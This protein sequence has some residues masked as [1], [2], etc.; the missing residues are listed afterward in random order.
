MLL[1][2]AANT[3]K[4][5][6]Y[7]P[8]LL[9]NI[10][11]HYQHSPGRALFRVNS[12]KPRDKSRFSGDWRRE[13][14]SGRRRRGRTRSPHPPVPWG[15]GSGESRPSAPS[16]QPGDGTAAR[17]RRSPGAGGATAASRAPRRSPRTAES[18]EGPGRSRPPSAPGPAARAAPVTWGADM[19][20]R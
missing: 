1:L 3:G 17:E 8:P 18:S 10:N 5:T 2:T 20:R 19:A 7:K 4:A 6:E 16:P 14:E 9:P 11:P 15:G 13:K 12:T